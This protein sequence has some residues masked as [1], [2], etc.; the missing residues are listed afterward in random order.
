MKEI[1]DH[2]LWYLRPFGVSELVSAA[3]LLT[4]VSHCCVCHS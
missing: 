1:C 3:L 4:N 2:F